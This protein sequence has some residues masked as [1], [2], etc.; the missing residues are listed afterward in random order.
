MRIYVDDRITNQTFI[1]SLQESIQQPHELILFDHQKSNNFTD[2]VVVTNDSTFFSEVQT[3]V[4]GV[5]TYLYA[6]EKDKKSGKITTNATPLVRRV[7]N[8]LNSPAITS[9][10][11]ED[12]P[13]FE[14]NELPNGLPPKVSKALKAFK[15][16]GKFEANSK[17]KLTFKIIWE[18]S[19]VTLAASGS[20][21]FVIFG[22][23]FAK[24]IFKKED[25]LVIWSLISSA[26][27][28]FSITQRS[29]DQIPDLIQDLKILMDKMI[30]QAHL[31]FDYK[32]SR[33]MALAGALILVLVN[34]GSFF[35]N[36]EFAKDTTKDIH[37]SIVAKV[38]IVLQLIAATALVLRSTVNKAVSKTYP[39]YGKVSQ[40]LKSELIGDL[41]SLL[42]KPLTEAEIARLAKGKTTYYDL[43]YVKW[44]VMSLPLL[45]TLLYAG[46]V[47]LAAADAVSSGTILSIIGGILAG[48]AS[49]ASKL[50]LLVDAE[51]SVAAKLVDFI[52]EQFGNS[53]IRSQDQPST[54]TSL[55]ISSSLFGLVAWNTWLSG[56][57]LVYKYLAQP[58]GELLSL[59]D[60]IQ[61]WSSSIIA[62]GATL[63]INFNDSDSLIKAFYHWFK[64]KY[65]RSNAQEFIK[66]LIIYYATL[67]D[68]AFVNRF[69]RK[70]DIES[71]CGETID[72][73]TSEVCGLVRNDRYMELLGDIGDIVDLL[74]SHYAISTD[75][76]YKAAS[77]KS[78]PGAKR[79]LIQAVCPIEIV[80]HSTRDPRQTYGGTVNMPK[81]GSRS[82]F[83]RGDDDQ[84]PSQED[85]H[86]TRL[87][88]IVVEHPDDPDRDQ[89]IYPVTRPGNPG[90]P[91]RLN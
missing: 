62:I 48:T 7:I 73:E 22:D 1:H 21:P 13:L 23:K 81:P 85:N 36:L 29:L 8:V 15:K 82:W 57:E 52:S 69:T 25:L 10:P 71:Q 31:H 66:T 4:P 11:T 72:Q 45:T 61:T 6:E 35:S 17:T 14:D 86:G 76:I 59:N 30:S 53:I 65:P 77:P 64:L 3:S 34:I 42:D 74:N 19:M 50:A 79:Q 80:V 90:M 49:S 40:I 58:L 27:V 26:L 91:G 41:N 18:L 33:P 38:L 78:F 83:F 28:N 68:R 56:A 89:E 47:G 32:L 46:G 5:C 16:L 44:F 88:Q 2:S 63:P 24:K 9:L 55:L 67:P 12:T 20:F 39:E 51:S 84:G 75:V 70:T 54:L 43:K 87:E 60:A 37:N